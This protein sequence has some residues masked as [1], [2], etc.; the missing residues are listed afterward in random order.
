MTDLSNETVMFFGRY[1][2]RYCSDS[3]HD[4]LHH[5]NSMIRGLRNAAK[6]KRRIFEES[7]IG[8]LRTGLFGSRHWV[9]TDEPQS[10]ICRFGAYCGFSAPNVGYQR[11]GERNLIDEL[12]DFS[13]WRGQNNQIGRLRPRDVND[14]QRLCP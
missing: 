4:L 13:N 8:D 11:L 14:V 10:A 3:A 12:E 1:Q 7:C 2:M 6:K 9:S 5:E